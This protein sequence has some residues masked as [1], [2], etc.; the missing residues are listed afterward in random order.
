MGVVPSS[1]SVAVT[2]VVLSAPIAAG[3]V[4]VSVVSSGVNVSPSASVLAIKKE[5]VPPPGSVICGPP[6]AKL[7]VT[8]QAQ[9]GCSASEAIVQAATP[10]AFVVALQVSPPDATV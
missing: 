10:A 1:F 5:A 4:V 7:A 9:P 8:T 2:L 6:P 3:D